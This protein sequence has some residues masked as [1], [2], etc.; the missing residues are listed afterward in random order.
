MSL[1]SLSKVLEMRRFSIM[2]VLKI[3]LPGKGPKGSSSRTP[4]LRLAL[5]AQCRPFL[6][7]SE[8][9]CT[10]R[11]DPDLVEGARVEGHICISYILLN[12]RISHFILGSQ[13]ILIVVSMNI[14]M[15]LVATIQALKKL[16]A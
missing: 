10:E 11:F 13:T 8:T 3:T 7:T 2:K 16:S 14:K 4:A 1:L 9:K 6:Q 12:V 5:L 15:E